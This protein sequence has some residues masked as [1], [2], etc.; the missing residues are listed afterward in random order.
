MQKFKGFTFEFAKDISEFF[1][2]KYFRL[3]KLNESAIG[4][5]ITMEKNQLLEKATG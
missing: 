4:N 5:V 3:D 1:A 2:A